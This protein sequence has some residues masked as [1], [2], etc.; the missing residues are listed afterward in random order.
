MSRPNAINDLIAP[1]R[2]ED[3][4]DRVVWSITYHIIPI[5]YFMPVENEWIDRAKQ[6]R[7][8]LTQLRDSL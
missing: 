2:N 3:K 1:G 6:I 7:E 4:I 5:T 8:R